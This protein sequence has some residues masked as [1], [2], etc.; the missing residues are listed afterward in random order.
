MI[1]KSRIWL[2][3]AAMLVAQTEASPAWSDTSSPGKATADQTSTLDLTSYIAF[4]SS[5][6]ILGGVDKLRNSIRWNFWFL[7]SVK[8]SPGFSAPFREVSRLV[9]HVLLPSS[10]YISVLFG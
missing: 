10:L 6:D 1:L 9:E 7:I 3:L 5:R 8:F 4:A 2:V